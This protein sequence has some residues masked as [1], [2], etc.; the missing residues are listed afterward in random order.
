MRVFRQ[1]YRPNVP[2]LETS[3]GRLQRSLR[4]VWPSHIARSWLAR[5]GCPI[6]NATQTNERDC[7]LRTARFETI[8]KRPQLLP[9]PGPLAGWTF[10]RQLSVAGLG[11]R[12]TCTSR[13]PCE[14]QRHTVINSQHAAQTCR[15]HSLAFVGAPPCRLARFTSTCRATEVCSQAYLPLHAMLREA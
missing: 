8:T 3:Q 5:V 15:V 4:Q 1:P 6:T 13:F 12:Q 2:G 7:T 14:P 9:G 10:Q 11:A